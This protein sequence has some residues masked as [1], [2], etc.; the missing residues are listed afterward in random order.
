MPLSAISWWPVLVVEEAKSI[1]RQPLTMGK[2][3]VNFITCGCKSSAPFF[4]IYKAGCEPTLYWWY[5]CMS[6][7][8]THW[9][10]QVLHLLRILTRSKECKIDPRF[11]SQIHNVSSNPELITYLSV[12]LIAT[13]A[14]SWPLTLCRQVP[15]CRSQRRIVPSASPLA[16]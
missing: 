13:T 2:Q 6:C 15:A 12:L 9:V 3:L 10:T 16:A 5:A 14:P 11:L 8:L 4:V 7:N 1:R